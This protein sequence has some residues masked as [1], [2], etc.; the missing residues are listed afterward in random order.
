[1]N[2]ARGRRGWGIKL[3]AAVGG[4]G[5]SPIAPGTVGAVGGLGCYLLIRYLFPGFVPETWAEVGPGYLVFLAIFF[6][7]G[8]R[9][10]TRAEREWRSRDDHRI[11]IDEAFSIF[12]SFLALPANLPVLAAAFILNRIFDV[13]KPFPV[14]RLE[15]VPAGW[16]VMLDDLAA[17]IYSRLVLA[18]LFYL[19]AFGA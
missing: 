15:Q 16:G 11:V 18:L 10:A 8:V 5:Y 14:R 3:L 17:G 1:M 2:S 19:G 7:A 9:I 4:L 12:V 13:V 6:L